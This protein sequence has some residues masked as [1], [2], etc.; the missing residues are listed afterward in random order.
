M[1]Q[2]EH[3][4]DYEERDDGIYKVQWVNFRGREK[5][6]F[7]EKKTTLTKIP[8][9][10]MNKLFHIIYYDSIEELFNYNELLNLIPVPD[11][12]VNDHVGPIVWI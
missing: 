10:Y 2:Y 9:G 5:L 6:W 12:S 4:S 1:N 11:R 8:Q 7:R 3:Y